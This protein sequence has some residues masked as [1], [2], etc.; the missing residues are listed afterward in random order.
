MNEIPF[1]GGA[2]IGLIDVDGHNFPNLCLMKISGFHKSIGNTVEWWDSNPE[3]HY[4]I[5]YMSKVFSDA[6]SPDV[7]TPINADKIIKGG[8]GYAITLE[9]GIEVYRK[10]LDPPLP[11]YIECAYPDYSIYPEYTGYGLSLKKQTAY[12]RL[13]QGCPRGCAFCHVAA[14]E[15]KCS[16][17]VA[18][19]SM[20]YE[21]QGSIC[22]GDPNIL[23][24]PQSIDLLEELHA[25]GAKI[26][27]NQ[28]LDARLITPRKA[29][30]LA[31]MKLK[32]PHFAMDTMEALE[33]ARKGMQMYVDAYKRLHGKW[34]WRNAK[35][36]CLTN[37][38]T[39]HAED[40]ERIKAIQDCQCQPYV[41]I[42]NK[43]SAPKI[44]RRLQ[45]WT[46]ST[47]LYA[48]FDDFYEY[49]RAQ[50]KSVLTGE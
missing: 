32:A 18:E 50:Y 22:L 3:K 37:F 8:T 17:K 35:C 1:R 2:V 14:K 43:P 46:N 16:R 26:E 4:D 29:E 45:R 10:E 33:P 34:D 9:N 12:G 21:G 5:V 25:T 13:T 48:R 40:M 15:G 38:G 28:G 41:M 49:Q 31:S 24:C 36:F 47:M 30:L 7:P 39:S 6:Y 23:A 20:F 42:Y 19:L 44:T 11:P 27:F